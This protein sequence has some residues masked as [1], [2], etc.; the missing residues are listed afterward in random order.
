M[1]FVTTRRKKASDSIE[2]TECTLSDGT[3]KHEKSD[4]VFS[5]VKNQN[6]N[7]KQSNSSASIGDD[8][9]RKNSGHLVHSFNR[10]PVVPHSVSGKQAIFAS[11]QKNKEAVKSNGVETDLYLLGDSGKKLKS[12]SGQKTI[13]MTNVEPSVDH[14][15]GTQKEENKTGRQS[16]KKLNNFNSEKANIC[17]Q[18]LVAKRQ[19]TSAKL[20]RSNDGKDEKL[21]DVTAFEQKHQNQESRKTRKMSKQQVQDT[22]ESNLKKGSNENVTSELDS[23]FEEEL[24][25]ERDASFAQCNSTSRKEQKILWS[26]GDA[27]RAYGGKTSPVRI[28]LHHPV[29][30]TPEFTNEDFPEIGADVSPE[31]L[32]RD[33]TVLSQPSQTVAKISYSAALKTPPSV[34]VNS[35]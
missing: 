8:S 35:M 3:K 31:K 6:F 15:V 33:S 17:N 34:K 26:S 10:S 19:E 9:Q 32:S 29:K 22:K 25:L 23:W 7:C 2:R 18:G 5:R 30:A 11:V 27:V 24:E 1:Q 14:E 16:G 4:V 21:K 20:S 28:L 12:N 13:V